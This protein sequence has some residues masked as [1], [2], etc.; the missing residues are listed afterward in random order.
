MLIMPADHAIPDRDAF[1]STIKT[2]LSAAQAGKLVL[3]GIPPDGP[4]TGY[5]YIQSGGPS[6]GGTMDVRAFIEKPNLEAAKR[7]IAA[8]DVFW[9]SGI[10]LLSASALVAEME[11]HEPRVL[12]AVRGSL[13]GARVTGN[14]TWLDAAAFAEAPSISIDHAVMERTALARVVAS[15]FIWSDIG[16]WGALWHLGDR[17]ASDNLRLGDTVAVNSSGSY[18]RSE[19]PLVAAVG[20][21]DLV[22]IATADAVL[23]AQR[24]AD[25]DVKT[26]VEQLRASNHRVALSGSRTLRPWGWYEALHSGD[27]FQVK[28]ISVDPGGMLS[29]QK[30]YHRA[31][32]WVVVNGTALVEVEGEE[33]LLSASGSIYVPLGATHRV[34]NPGKIPLELIEVQTGDY[35]GEDDIVRFEDIYARI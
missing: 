32:H 19:G 17:D 1:L 11:T 33:K 31:E 4:A 35:T 12:S 3:F 13:A 2:G 16:Q 14:V 15:D 18:I 25:Q 22:I 24:G 23:V 5:G 10:F 28:R 26:V 9:N 8:G 7:Y 29:L 30:H 21:Q 6:V 27:R 20:V 34:S